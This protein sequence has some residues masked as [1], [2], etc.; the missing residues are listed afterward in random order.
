[1]PS[2]DGWH[3]SLTGRYVKCGIWICC[4]PLSDVVPYGGTFAWLGFPIVAH[5]VTSVPNLPHWCNIFS[6]PVGGRAAPTRCRKPFLVLSHVGRRIWD[7]LTGSNRL[8][9]LHHTCTF[10]LTANLCVNSNKHL[11]IT[12]REHS[13]LFIHWKQCP[14]LRTDFSELRWPETL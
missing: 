14:A 12:L 6:V 5:F 2:L 10:D 11:V 3:L 7:P 13:Y 8:C 9:I 4:E 1:M